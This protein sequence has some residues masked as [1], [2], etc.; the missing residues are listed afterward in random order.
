MVPLLKF[1]AQY[2]DLEVTTLSAG[3]LGALRSSTFIVEIEQTLE[4]DSPGFISQ[5]STFKHKQSE[6][7]CFSS[8]KINKTRNFIR[9]FY[10]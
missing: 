1:G 6:P 10:R 2:H 5:P 4:S 3:L 7:I 8:S 9:L